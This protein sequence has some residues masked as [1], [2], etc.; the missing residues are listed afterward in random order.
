M[1]L[2]K[3]SACDLVEAIPP[4][5]RTR[6]PFLPVIIISPLDFRRAEKT[7]TR[8]RNAQEWKR[9]KSRLRE[10]G[11]SVPSKNCLIILHRRENGRKE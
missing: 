5:L 10:A 1:L 6:L 2:R 9:L 7:G 11:C 4:I 8:D 3:R